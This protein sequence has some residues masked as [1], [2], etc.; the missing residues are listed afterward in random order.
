MADFC[1]Q[2]SEEYFGYDAKDFVSE[3][4]TESMFINE[5]KILLSICEGCGYI[6]TNHL[7]ECV[8]LDCEKHGEE[9]KVKFPV[10]EKE[11]T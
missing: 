4:L 5:G 10:K 6:E 9:N 1:K 7:G 8:S 3:S 2:C 11:I